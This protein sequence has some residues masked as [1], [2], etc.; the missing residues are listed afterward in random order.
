MTTLSQHDKQPRRIRKAYQSLAKKHKEQLIEASN[1]ALKHF[2]NDPV[3]AKN[4]L[5]EINK[6]FEWDSPI[7]WILLSKGDKVL[8]YLKAKSAL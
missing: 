6:D 1:L 4:W 5:Y 7:E 8:E 2:N 3:E